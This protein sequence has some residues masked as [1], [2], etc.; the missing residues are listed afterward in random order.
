[1]RHRANGGERLDPAVLRE[2]RAALVA[3][4]SVAAALGT[5]VTDGPLGALSRDVRLGRPLVEAA[6]DIDTDDP[7]ADL[8]VRA[9]AV[10]EHTGAGAGAAVDQALGAVREE[11]ALRRLLRVRTAQARATG[12]VLCGLPV[13]AWLLLVALD[14]AA[15]RF[16]ATPLGAA[17]ALA[18]LG[19]CGGSWAVVGRLVRWA[20]AAGAAAE[21]LAP[22]PPALSWLRAA[23]GWP[24]AAVPGPEVRGG[25]A[26]A[27]ELL[28]I[29]LQAGLSPA[30]ALDVVASVR[31]PLAAPRLAT[32]SRRLRAGWGVAAAFEGTGLVPLGAALAASE[33]WGAPATD[34]IR[35]LAAELRAERRAAA[36]EAAERLQVALVFPTTLLTL[37]G[38]VL[39]VVP[40]L[41]WTALAGAGGIG[42]P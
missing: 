24:R 20:G 13:V 15:L 32:A 40:P 31:P 41:L 29:A 28:A 25:T 23:V 6:A 5:V 30:A 3:G 4:A 33:R 17:T 19:L 12:A 37:P 35:D 34:T 9:L 36:E 39:A 27:A 8:L 16:Y 22:S 11:S 7:T 18:A 14:G 1:M 42:L 26:E 10:V 21:P 38:F 2:L